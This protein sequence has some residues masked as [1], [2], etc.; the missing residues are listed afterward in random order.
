MLGASCN[1]LILQS[2]DISC[3]TYGRGQLVFGDHLGSLYFLTRHFELTSFKAYGIRVT[4]LH[5]AKQHGILVSIGVRF[6]AQILIELIM[7]LHYRK[8]KVGLI[9]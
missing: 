6:F 9:L 4:H 1:A 8:M 2:L 3:S 5:Q 7:H